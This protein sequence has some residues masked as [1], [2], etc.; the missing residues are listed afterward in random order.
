MSR[1][2][3]SIHYTTSRDGVRLAWARSGQ[4][5]SLVKTANWITHLEYDWNSTAWRHW[6]DFFSTHFSM[7]RYDE[8]GNGLSQ[9]EVD[10]VSQK[11]W[12]PDLETVVEAAKPA[13]PFVLL[14]ISQGSVAAIEFAARY[15]ERVSHLILFG[16]YSVGW[17]MRGNPEHERE[18]EALIAFTELG[19]GRSDPIYRRLF[20]KR[21]LPEGT[22]E[23]LTWFDE[24]C[25]ATTS[26]AMAAKL[27]DSR[28]DVDVSGLLGKINTP[29]LVLH[30]SKDHVIPFQNGQEIA[31]GIPGSEFIQLDSCNHILLES[32]PAWDRFR[33]KVL[34]FT[35]VESR[36]IMPLFEQLS[37]REREILAEIV[38][39]KTNQEIGDLLFISEKTVRNHIT[40]IFEKLD[41]KTR[42]QAM[43]LALKNGFVG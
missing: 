43:V 17:R 23:Q 42:A 28:A 4:G 33:E 19:W 12:L 14:G 29:T 5:P 1:Q 37:A 25:A 20:T 7:T 21:F 18:Y 10:D 6:V 9:H 41:V 35:Q 30:V 16:G 38:A 15:P 24:L 8:R 22:E 32:E 39:G 2:S 11:H 27:L 31:A 36:Q 26:P 40:H 3:Q 34:D 13:E